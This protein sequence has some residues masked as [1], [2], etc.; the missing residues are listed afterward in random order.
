MN[1]DKQDYFFM[2][3]IV[4]LILLFAFLAIWHVTREEKS[5]VD[6][7]PFVKESG[8]GD[9]EDSTTFY[10]Y[11]L[12]TNGMV[13]SSFYKCNP[14]ERWLAREKIDYEKSFLFLNENARKYYNEKLIGLEVQIWRRSLE[15]NQ[16]YQR[17]K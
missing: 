5:T 3:L 2:S 4:F 11:I 8:Y 9:M 1:F 13:D 6:N 10:Y 14:K 12:Y 17:K 7:F 15:K 16:T